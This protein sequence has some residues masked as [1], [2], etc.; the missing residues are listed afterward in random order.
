MT[1][2]LPADFFV[3]RRPLFAIDDY[4]AIQQR[5]QEGTSLA[6]ALQTVYTDL[7]CQEAL[8]YAS[9][10][11]HTL[12]VDWL[13]GRLK[14]TDSF[15]F[16][17]YKYYIRMTTR[18]TPFGLF[19]GISLGAWGTIS[20]LQAR[21][22]VTRNV[23][24]DMGLLS[25]LI[26]VINDLP[27]VRQQLLY[28]PNESLW[29]V[30]NTLRYVAYT[31]QD[32]QRTYYQQAVDTDPTL[33][34]VLDCAQPG[35]SFG[36]LVGLLHTSGAAASEASAY[37]NALIDNQLLCSELSATLT[38]PDPLTVLIARLSELS[39]TSSLVDQLN[40]VQHLLGQRDV[41]A[42]RQ[43]K[44]LLET[45]LPTSGSS[46]VQC[47]AFLPAD[48]TIL[49]AS[50]KTE[51]TTSLSNLANR[52]PPLAL[53][54]LDAFRH[55]FFA[56]YEHQSVPLLTALDPD[57]GVGYD[58]QPGVPTAWLDSLPWIASAPS[59]PTVTPVSEHLLRLYSQAIRNRHFTITL[60]INDLDC[61][62]PVQLNTALPAS[63]YALGQ[64][65]RPADGHAPLFLLKGMGGP[66][67]ANLL[68]RFA[69]LSPELETSLRH[70]L[71]D[72]QASYPNVRLAEL[73]HLPSARTGNVLRRPILREYEIPILTQSAVPE[74]QQL[75]LH[76]LFVNMPNGQ[77]VVL[78]SK[79]LNQRIVPRLSTA[80]NVL[81]GGLMHYRFLYDLQHQEASL[82]VGWD[83]GMLTTMPFLPRVQFQTVLLSRA[84]WHLRLEDIGHN[85][86]VDWTSWR[87]AQGLPRFV[88]LVEGD[89]ELVLDVETQ[90]GR[91]LLQQTLK[92]DGQATLVEWLDAT[93]ESVV[94]S[95]DLKRWNHELLIPLH[96][97]R[98]SFTPVRSAAARPSDQ[99][100]LTRHF[101]PGSQWVYL[102]LYAG[103]AYLDELL[104]ESLPDFLTDLA[105]R[106]LI[107]SWFFIRYLDPQN[108][109][110]IRF[111]ATEAQD[112]SLLDAVSAWANQLMTTDSRVMQV[113]FDTYQREIE[114]FGSTTIE[115][116]E[117]WFWY[118]SRAVL[119][120]LVLLNG[121]PDW[122]RLRV[123]CL[124][125]H[126]LLIAWQYDPIS[127]CHLVETWRDSF[128]RE[129]RVDKS[130]QTDVNS[131]FRDHK[132]ALVKP[133]PNE[134][135]LIGLL[136]DYHAQ[137]AT[138]HKNLQTADAQSPERLLSSITHL[139]LNRLFIDSQRKN[140]LIV[141]C[142]L[143]KLI[144]QW[145]NTR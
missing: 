75:P 104:L 116:C 25:Q 62:L 133:S 64:L 127:Q 106:Q 55:R 4:L 53:P 131:L 39:E 138:F 10:A 9:P 63:G 98:P 108:H 2:L 99:A 144:K 32:G 21:P 19:A 124:F 139:F 101:A 51:L 65:I 40:Q 125:V 142:F 57:L 72:E 76:D 87:L 86:G 143:S 23:R 128:L 141:Y 109:L 89:N 130:F 122:Q 54:R 67:A 111:L 129:F 120:L 31:E 135:I 115:I 12:L 136:T 16:T 82:R 102:K 36:Q 44:S 132:H 134:Q 126:Q 80:H 145:L 107:Q 96:R 38:G 28:K 81:S 15:L 77:Q 103:C 18:S 95:D 33:R 97:E 70:C 94:R 140:E 110:R 56:R 69:H 27:I 7:R 78:Y 24:L 79:K 84:R 92:R 37:L 114:R 100:L 117:N 93:T 13:G 61:I 137:A 118:D 123:G 8:F 43:L 60:S 52:S 91:T 74:P 68:G 34:Q 119:N 48:T 26:G 22:A 49:S 90:A 50:L 105:Q 59:A 1:Q 20:D 73:V 46:L 83:W 11:V 66:S 58:S 47:D 88:L 17:L 29:V 41:A 35:V 5:L 112:R 3:L 6:D 42:H 14:P 45:L 121:Q 113:Q 71:Q 30:G 85:F